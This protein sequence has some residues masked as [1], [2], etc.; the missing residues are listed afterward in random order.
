MRFKTVTLDYISEPLTK[1]ACVP[2]ANHKNKRNVT[3]PNQSV[4]RRQE[5]RIVLH[6][7]SLFLPGIFL[8][9]TGGT[10]RRA[11]Q[12]LKEE[13]HSFNA[14][15][16]TASLFEARVCVR[17]FLSVHLNSFRQGG[18][19]S[20]PAHW[21]LWNKASHLGG[22][23]FIYYQRKCHCCRVTDA[24]KFLTTWSHF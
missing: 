3:S 22:L 18:C 9:L 13:S 4:N 2:A 8:L 10:A 5:V 12:Q 16:P 17:A 11:Y 23:L 14:D 15:S 6:F 21:P 19:E 20:A 1:T 7:F 24:F